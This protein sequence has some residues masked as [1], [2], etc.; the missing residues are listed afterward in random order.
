MV[1]LDRGEAARAAAVALEAL[2]R[3]WAQGD[4]AAAIECLVLLTGAAAALGRIEPAGRLI[5]ASDRL[6]DVLGIVLTPEFERM[7]GRAAV[8]A[9][10]GEDRAAEAFAA[11]RTLPLAASSPRRARWRPSSRPRQ[12][13]R[14]P[15]R[16][17]TA[18][19]RARWRCCA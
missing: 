18:L 10:L 19:P 2:N 13:P 8:R 17:P 1:A 11:G 15:G 3:F 16:L 7:D 9:G 12:A 5:G 14:P 4:Q 6:R